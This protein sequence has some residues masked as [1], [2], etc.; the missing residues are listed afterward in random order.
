MQRNASVEKELIIEEM[1]QFIEIKQLFKKIAALQQQLQKVN[2]QPDAAFCEQYNHAFDECLMHCQ[3]V[4]ELCCTVLDYSQY[5]IDEMGRNVLAV[6]AKKNGHLII[7]HHEEKLIKIKD[8]YHEF[9]VKAH[10]IIMKNY[11]AGKFQ[12]N[13]TK[14]KEA[15]VALQYAINGHACGMMLENSTSVAVEIQEIADYQLMLLFEVAKLEQV[16]EMVALLKKQKE[17]G[18]NHREFAT[19]HLYETRFNRVITYFK[20][21]I[22]I[23]NEKFIRNEGMKVQEN[24]RGYIEKIIISHFN[25]TTLYSIAPNHCANDEKGKFSK[26]QLLAIHSGKM[27][28][29]V[30]SNHLSIFDIEKRNHF[31]MM[32]KKTLFLMGTSAYALATQPFGENAS[33]KDNRKRA[34]DYFSQGDKLGDFKAQHWLARMEIENKHY[35]KAYYLAISAF[36]LDPE[37]SK[38]AMNDLIECL[39]ADLFSTTNFN[40]SKNIIA[41]INALIKNNR[42][43]LKPLKQLIYMSGIHLAVGCNKAETTKDYIANK[44]DVIN[45]AI[46][47]C[48]DP[49]TLIE[50]LVNYIEKIINKMHANYKTEDCADESRYGELLQLFVGCMDKKFD[51]DIKE[52]AVTIAYHFSADKEGSSEKSLEEIMSSV[53]SF[54]RR[55][56]LSELYC[57]QG[58]GTELYRLLGQFYAANSKKIIL[59]ENKNKKT[60][61]RQHET[62]DKEIVYGVVVWLLN[63]CF[64]GIQGCMPLLI[65]SCRKLDIDKKSQDTLSSIEFALLSPILFDEQHYTALEHFLLKLEKINPYYRIHIGYQYA[66]FLLRTKHTQLKSHAIRMANELQKH[67]TQF[68]KADSV[69]VKKIE[70]MQR[71]DMFCEETQQSNLSQRGVAKKEVADAETKSSLL[72][73]IDECRRSL[74]YYRI[75][76]ADASVNISATI[77]EQFSGKQLTEDDKKILDKLIEALVNLAEFD[78]TDTPESN[79]NKYRYYGMVFVTAVDFRAYKDVAIKIDGA[80]LKMINI[81]RRLVNNCLAKDYCEQEFEIAKSHIRVLKIMAEQIKI[82]PAFGV[83][84]NLDFNYYFLFSKALLAKINYQAGRFYHRAMNGDALLADESRAKAVA[85]YKKANKYYDEISEAYKEENENSSDIL[86]LLDDVHY[87]Y[88]LSLINLRKINKVELISESKPDELRVL[89][90]KLLMETAQ[91]SH[92]AADV[93]LAKIYLNELKRPEYAILFFLRSLLD[94][95]L[96]EEVRSTFLYTGLRGLSF[97]PLFTIDMLERFYRQLKLQNQRH[98]I[99]KKML[100]NHL[101]ELILLLLVQASLLKKNEND[102]SKI[103]TGINGI[104]TLLSRYD[105]QRFDH[106]FTILLDHVSALI[107]ILNRRDDTDIA[108]HA[109]AMIEDEQK[110]PKTR[111]VKKSAGSPYQHSD[112]VDFCKLSFIC[113]AK[114][115]AEHAT[116]IRKMII[117][118]SYALITENMMTLPAEIKSVI[119]LLFYRIALHDLT[120]SNE[121]DAIPNFV[122]SHELVVNVALFYNGCPRLLQLIAAWYQHVADNDNSIKGSKRDI[123]LQLRLQKQ[124]YANAMG[125]N[126]V[127]MLQGSKAAWKNF[128]VVLTSYIQLTAANNLTELSS[129]Q[130]VWQKDKPLTPS[131]YRSLI[132]LVEEVKPTNTTLGVYVGYSLAAFLVN[133]DVCDRVFNREL[134]DKAFELVTQAIE[135]KLHYDASHHSPFD[136]ESKLIDIKM[137]ELREMIAKKRDKY[138][139]AQMKTSKKDKRK[140]GRLRTIVASNESDVEMMPQ[141]MSD[142]DAHEENEQDERD[143]EDTEVAEVLTYPL[144]EV[145]SLPMSTSVPGPKMGRSIFEILELNEKGSRKNQTKK[146]NVD[147]PATEN[148]S[149]GNGKVPRKKSTTPSKIKRLQKRAKEQTKKRATVLQ[150]T[151]SPLLSTVGL[152]EVHASEHGFNEITAFPPEVLNCMATLKVG[153]HRCILT[154]SSIWQ[155]LIYRDM[156]PGTDY[157]FIT[158]ATAEEVQTMEMMGPKANR[159]GEDLCRYF[160]GGIQLDVMCSAKAKTLLAHAMNRDLTIGALYLEIEDN[161]IKLYDPTGL[162]LMHLKERKVE[163]IGCMRESFAEDNSRI[164]NF[165]KK[166]QHFVRDDGTLFVNLYSHHWDEMRKVKGVLQDIM[167]NRDEKSLGHF[168]AK[169]A[170]LFIN[171]DASYS[172]F[173]CRETGLFEK[174]F[175]GLNLACPVLYKWLNDKV[176]NIVMNTIRDPIIFYTILDHIVAALIVCQTKKNVG[177]ASGLI[178]EVIYNNAILHHVYCELGVIDYGRILSLAN[179]IKFHQKMSYTKLIPSS[180]TFW[181]N[182]LA[183]NAGKPNAPVQKR[184]QS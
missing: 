162:A 72:Q 157:D 118:S 155:K 50:Q 25:L 156:L 161:K 130:I 63:A 62:V 91:N 27:A 108:L 6:I 71:G 120:N 73:T 55:V 102:F 173:L 140:Y 117:D 167:L 111:S 29:E 180:I 154:G 137:V 81:L 16:T 116:L 138:Q 124:R 43:N 181:Q 42:S 96:D 52:V 3:Q 36:L 183:T 144:R 30:I 48:K 128:L 175:T 105:A 126:F 143:D 19:V 51:I 122:R 149:S 97:E 151:E 77:G 17:K 146:N 68:M 150:M 40:C 1:Q 86:H 98:S 169:L 26:L 44:F 145:S 106:V 67:V 54:S 15:T 94:K 176:N 45:E 10:C 39:P 12:R 136:D 87:Q 170:A 47:K 164:F 184:K 88:A 82:L 2:K 135:N 159:F 21:V 78:S 109:L 22:N 65:D 41:A 57:L 107:K 134:L 7:Q 59:P 49:K 69:M 85:F 13:K 125:F 8:T 100:I 75:G 113:E 66:N 9:L 24:N 103:V 11:Y 166:L 153:G 32:Y 76:L 99:P 182:G 34:H 58:K 23:A 92:Y 131:L 110:K 142:D 168:Q 20:A 179:E 133:A 14:N 93:K 177:N 114:G 80:A 158:T 35:Q 163:T 46:A 115:Y 174:I 4:I 70:A 101:S 56:T 171:W 33:R 83:E 61:Q 53:S 165:L 148:V 90:M 129:F 31:G 79:V 89:I 5:H 139:P 104:T 38:D 37:H 132:F 152:Q 95:N 123:A 28:L 60:K 147:K 64:C 127:A 121:R 160:Q 112:I 74:G 172:L 178:A 119:G 141:L 84:S 18:K